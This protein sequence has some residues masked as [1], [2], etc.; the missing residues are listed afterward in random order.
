MRWTGKSYQGIKYTKKTFKI[1]FSY[2][3]RYLFFVFIKFTIRPFDQSLMTTTTTT[4]INATDVQNHDI[5]YQKLTNLRTPSSFIQKYQTKTNVIPSI[6]ST[7]KYPFITSTKKDEDY[8]GSQ[9]VIGN[10]PSNNEANARLNHVTSDTVYSTKVPGTYRRPLD[11]QR[12]VDKISSNSIDDDLKSNF[13]IKE[14][15]SD[16]MSWKK[17]NDPKFVSLDLDRSYCVG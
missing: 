7:N 17:N 3:S 1:Q 5:Q 10:D 2:Y 11:K 14:K 12:L 16:E 6:V 13:D 8:N 15:L 4:P 9:I